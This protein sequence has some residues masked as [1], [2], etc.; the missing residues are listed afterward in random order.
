MSLR[1]RLL[2][3]HATVLLALGILLAITVRQMHGQYEFN[4]K[5]QVGTSVLRPLVGALTSAARHQALSAEGRQTEAT[6]AARE[7]DTRIEELRRASAEHGAMLDY[8]AAGLESRGRSAAHPDRISALWRDG[9]G[10]GG[11]AGSAAAAHS[12]SIAALRL[13]ITHVGDTSNLILDP[14]LDSYYL[15]DVVLCA[16]PQ[17][18]D[19]LGAVG[20]GLAAMRAKPVLTAADRNQLAVWAAHLA[21]SDLAR[22]VGDQDTVI[23]EDANFMGRSETVQQRLPPALAAWC[24]PLEK[25]IAD[26]RTAAQGGALPAASGVVECLDQGLRY[27]LVGDEELAALIAPR[28]SDYRWLRNVCLAVGLIALALIALA[29]LA[30]ERFMARL[31]RASRPLSAAGG[32]IQVAARLVAEQVAA[33]AERSARSAATLE[34]SSG[35]LHLIGSTLKHT[36]DNSQ[37]AD[38]LST[39]ARA[40][41]ESG[42]KAMDELRTAIS[43]IKMVA[44]QTARIVKTIDEIA[45][46]TNLLALNAAVEAARAG[47]A[48]KGF[49]VVAEEVRNLAQRAGEAA[50]NS[51]QL[52]DTS[53]Q[54]AAKGVALSENANRILADLA[55]ANRKVSDLIGEIAAATREQAR[56][57]DQLLVSVSELDH[58]S[59]ENAAATE[60]NA[61]AA[62]ELSAQAMA[63]NGMLDEVGRAVHGS[64]V[65]D[66]PGTMAAKMVAPAAAVGHVTRHRQPR[67]PTANGH[68]ANGHGLGTG[69]SKSKAAIP[70]PDDD[71]Q[72]LSRF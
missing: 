54:K 72:A 33:Q 52:I 13:A 11:G 8:T 3:L 39:H 67:P 43:E 1:L 66:P 23:K 19:R 25:L 16:L 27:W 18:Q 55:G 15:M 35:N 58:L 31:A 65:A 6:S 26:L 61:S 28:A 56:G 60:E 69:S 41:A 7:V 51:A 42:T 9:L 71:H 29:S 48:G 14:D 12:A 37:A 20:A 10:S 34:Q 24:A 50:R 17:V 47:D 44:D 32:Q 70:F 21:D 40:S 45:F 5:E 64:G 46:Q 2:L 68:L 62:E 38:S 36:A 63:V 57:V 59:Q 49:A 22:V 53:V 4:R 30:L